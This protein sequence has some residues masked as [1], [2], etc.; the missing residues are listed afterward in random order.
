V[1]V[2]L[3]NAAVAVAPSGKALTTN[4]DALPGKAAARVY[5]GL[6]NVA[7]EI[8]TVDVPANSPTTITSVGGW[9][10]AIEVINVLE[11]ASAAL[12]LNAVTPIAFNNVSVPTK[13][14]V[15]LY[16]G[17]VNVA[18]EA[19]VQVALPILARV[20]VNVGA[21]YTPIAASTDF[22]PAIAAAAVYDGL[23]NVAVDAIIDVLPVIA[24]AAEYVGLVNVSVDA[25]T[26]AL[27]TKTTAAV[28]V[29]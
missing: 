18:V 3:L 19:I 11:L 22:W 14:I 6:V 20:I 9:T 7:A 21:V 2:A 24:T 29:F 12:N 4:I 10:V 26:E 13:T 23:V 16:V 25:N 15:P 17:L 28:Y 1:E 5:V 8:T 27:E